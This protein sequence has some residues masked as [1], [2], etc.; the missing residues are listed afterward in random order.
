MA[1]G[2]TDILM[3]LGIFSTILMLISFSIGVHYGIEQFTK[4]YF[5]ANLINFF[6]VMFLVM[7]FINGTMIELFKK[8][9]EII[10]SSFAMMFFILAIRKYF[11]YFKNIDN[12]YVLAII[13]FLAMFFYFIVISVF[14]PINV[15]NRIKSLKLRKSFF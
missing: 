10:I 6:P 1:K 14:N 9:F 11:I 3:R 13:V 5:V 4:F 8:I 7:K 12:F 2:R 15:K